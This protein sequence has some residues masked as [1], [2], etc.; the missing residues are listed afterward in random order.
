VLLHEMF[1]LRR[2]DVWINFAQALL[3]IVYWWHPLLWFA[4]ARIRRLREEAVDDAVMLALRDRAETYAPT[5]LEVAKLTFHRPLLTLGLVGVME[6]RSALRQRIERLLDFRAP[7][8]AGLTCASLLTIFGFSV[9]ALPMG[10]APNSVHSQFITETYSPTLAGQN[11]NLNMAV[12]DGILA[13]PDFF[14][15]ALGALK[16][17]GG[18]TSIA[19]PEV[20]TAY[21]EDLNWWNETA[22]WGWEKGNSTVFVNT[23]MFLNKNNDELFTRTFNLNSNAF[24]SFYSNFQISGLSPTDNFANSV[25]SLLSRLGVNWESPKGKSI[26]YK[27]R[28]RLLFVNATESDLDLVERTVANLSQPPPEIHIKCRFFEAPKETLDDLNKSMLLP[29]SAADGF[30]G[31]LNSQNAKVTF[32]E[33][34]SRQDVKLLAEPEVTITRE[35][36]CKMRATQ[37]ITVVT[38]L[39]FK[40]TWANQNEVLVTNAVV[41]QTSQVEIGAILDVI[42]HLLADGYT[43][44][45]DL[46]S[47][48]TEFLG[49]NSSTKA[50]DVYY[51]AGDRIDPDVLHSFQID[52]V[53]LPSFRIRKTSVDLNQWDGQTA[54]IGDF[55]QT[56]WVGG[57]QKVEP[58]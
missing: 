53:I 36:Q 21:K 57:K 12:V 39:L 18:S 54:V 10:G 24:Y 50:Y 2:R 3:Q 23:N 41:P 52:P 37:I 44:N 6:S 35:R 32:L 55:K 16:Q 33:F 28:L 26:F 45:L 20:V 30:V 51:K 8:K 38:N 17:H 1:H 31:I 42:P 5:L 29:S 25:K 14:R 7:R 11:T 13:D 9:V 4:N 46:N 15:S 34:Q 19:E 47:S 48:L 58:D 49:Y 27:D 43:I 40:D 22:L 56:S